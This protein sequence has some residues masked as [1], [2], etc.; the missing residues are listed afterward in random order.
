MDCFRCGADDHLYRDC[1]QDTTAAATTTGGD[2]RPWCGDCDKRTRLLDH[3]SHMERC[4]RCWAWP[5]KGTYPGQ[6]LPQHKRCGGCRNLVYIWDAFPCGSH[7]PLS[8]AA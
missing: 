4:R 2:R 5:A 1:P 6:L 3:G 8:T 7:Q